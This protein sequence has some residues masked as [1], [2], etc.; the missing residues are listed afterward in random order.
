MVEQVVGSGQGCGPS[1]SHVRRYS[2]PVP[3]ELQVHAACQ[4]REVTAAS[5]APASMTALAGVATEK[6]GEAVQNALASGIGQVFLRSMTGG[7]GVS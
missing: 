4:R 7:L 2:L 3:T 6:G 5:A 1:T